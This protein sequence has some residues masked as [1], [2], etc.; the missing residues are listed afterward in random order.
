[1]RAFTFLFSVLAAALVPAC[2]GDDG[3][4]TATGDVAIAA[5]GVAPKLVRV[6]G[7]GCVRFTNQDTAPHEMASDP[8]PTHGN[9]PELN[10]GVIPAGQSQTAQMFGGPKT[11][12]FH[13]HRAE[14]V[15]PEP[16]F[17]GTVEVTSAAP[18]G[19]GGGY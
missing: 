19:G 18:S 11:C 15:T 9:C 10:V 2:G 12:G 3:G 16:A 1:M 5:T 13:E 8:H 14:L 4:C 7:G 17:Q 6:P